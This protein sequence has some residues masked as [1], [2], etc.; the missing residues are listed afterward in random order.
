MPILPLFGTSTI[1]R[2]SNVTA[3]R[4]INLYAEQQGEA[5]KAALVFFGRPG[6][7]QGFTTAPTASSTV[8]G[9]LRGIIVS[10]KYP[11]GEQVYAAQGDKGLLATT[12]GRFL[13][14]PGFFATSIGPVQFANVG[15]QVLAVDGAKGYQMGTGNL[16]AYGFWNGAT[17][18]CALA[19][20][21][22]VN[23]P[24]NP[25]RFYWSGVS[26]I[27]SWPA[28]NFAT[29]ESDS[30]TLVQVFTRGGELLLFGTRTLEFWAPTGG[31]DVFARTGGASIDWGLPVFDSPRKIADTVLFIGQSL[32]G[33]PQVCMLNGYQV[34]VVSTPDIE[35]NITRAIQAG[36]LPQTSAVTAAGHAWYLVHLDDTSYAFDVTT[37]IWGEWQTAGGRFCGQYTAA[38]QR[39]LLIT[40][41][42]DGRVYYVEPD[43]ILDGDETIDREIV[44][45]HFFVDLE[46]VGLAKLTL[47]MENGDYTREGE[48]LTC[49]E[50]LTDGGMAGITASAGAT[51][52]ASFTVEMRLRLPWVTNAPPGSQTR[53]L[54]KNA[55]DWMVY[56]K[57]VGTLTGTWYL[58]FETGSSTAVNSRILFTDDEEFHAAFV[59]DSA[60]QTLS[61]YKNGVL[62][63]T[64]TGIATMNGATATT[65]FYFGG[66]TTAD[67]TA[68]GR[69]GL[70]RIWD[71]TRTAAQILANMTTILPDGEANM[72]NQWAY[73]PVGATSWTSNGSAATTVT[74]TLP[75][76]Y[77]VG[78]DY[79]G[80]EFDDA[81]LIPDRG[82]E[83]MLQISKDGGHSFG[84]EL[85]QTLGKSGEYRR[86]VSWRRLG[87]SRDF[88]FRVRVTDPAKVVLINA[89]LDVGGG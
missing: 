83:V 50:A 62:V 30:D 61:G 1:G 66:G 58:A 7:R 12:S 25:G 78:V 46:R 32:G 20:R 11:S 74:Y 65:T 6:L 21:F 57:T 47:D 63:G 81:K 34:R 49:L 80:A 38:Y 87:V 69:I 33:E 10:P 31:A 16:D 39:Q 70:V 75:P 53:V 43:Q 9:P 76:P 64:D 88:V 40:D 60:A 28:L 41:Y 23:D 79:D 51:T 4:R 22:I 24:D 45:R 82:A 19:S 37:G 48:G 26:D 15:L 5:D 71:G 17:S 2:S 59:Y 36:V 72:V 18:C 8:G 55:S 84:N 77:A 13:D 52:T 35:I 42:R 85:W 86:Q 44:S 68:T 27:T 3:Q 54:Q 73:F 29:A 67:V 14:D 89:A 56:R